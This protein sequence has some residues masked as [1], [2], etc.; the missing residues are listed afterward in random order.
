[1][2]IPSARFPAKVHSGGCVED[3]TANGKSIKYRQEVKIQK[4]L[5]LKFYRFSELIPIL[6]IATSSMTALLNGLCTG[7]I[8]TGTQDAYALRS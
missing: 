8:N 4:M 1:M 7:S 6:L 3:V 2:S 5:N